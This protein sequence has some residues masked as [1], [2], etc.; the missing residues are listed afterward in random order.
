MV[1]NTPRL[2][3]RS[4]LW[5]FNDFKFCK[6]KQTFTSECCFLLT[7]AIGKTT[8]IHS[9]KMQS[10]LFPLNPTHNLLLPT[11]LTLSMCSSAKCR[12]LL[13]L[14]VPHAVTLS[15]STGTCRPCGSRAALPGHSLRG[16]SSSAQK[17]VCFQDL[18][19]HVCV[20]QG[21][22]NFTRCSR[23]KTAQAPS[24]FQTHWI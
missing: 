14:R 3:L 10:L 11:Q 12:N 17:H 8:S 9:G 19:Y 18:K 24:I 6:K 1:T 16:A 4:H 21:K 22:A 5:Y 7:S 15:L 23:A 13:A 20:H 2:L